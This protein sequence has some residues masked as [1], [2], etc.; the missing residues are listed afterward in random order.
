MKFASVVFFTGGMM[1]GLVVGILMGID[2]PTPKGWVMLG[3]MWL[4]GALTI[5]DLDHAR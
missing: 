1:M 4:V 3:I 2:G 5:P